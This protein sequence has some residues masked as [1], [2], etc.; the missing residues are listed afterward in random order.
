M[1]PTDYKRVLEEEEKKLELAKKNE[2]SGYLHTVREDPESDATNGEVKK[3]KSPPTSISRPVTPQPSAFGHHQHHN[4]PKVQDL[5]DTIL[6]IKAE[7][8][9]PK[10]LALDKTKGFMTYKQRNEKYRPATSR[11]KD[12]Q[13]FTTRLTKE[14][15]KYQTARCM[16]CGVPFC[17]SDTG[18]PISNVI[19]KWNE[20]IFKDRWYEALQRLLMTN[21]FPEFT[22][23]ICPAPCEGA[24]VLGIN[25]DPVGIKSIE[26]AIIDH[27]F[28]QGWIVP[29]PPQQR[30]G[31]SVVIVGSG[32]AG[33]AA[34]DQLN[35]AGHSV[36][37]YERSDRAGGLLMYGIPNMKLDKKVV[38]RR[39]N[40]MRDEGVNFVTNTTVG[41]D[42]TVSDLKAN[43]DA[44]VFAVGSTI[45]RDLKIPGRSL[46]N[47]MF[48]MQLLKWNTK[49]L[50]EDN[51]D[52]VRELLHD[53]HVIVIGGGDT[54]N[55]CL[56]TSVRHGAKS[57]TNFELLPKPAAARGKDNPWPQWPR[58]FRV[59]YG[60]SEVTAHYGKDPR[61]Y[62]ILSKEFVGDEEVMSKVSRLFEL[63]GRNPK[64]ELGRCLKFQILKNFSQPTLYYCQWDLLV[65]KL[66]L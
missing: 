30:T 64:A 20:L 27:G 63:N 39:L 62:S 51:L 28:E 48:A 54:G 44:V 21:N 13:E 34:A 56:G 43:N 22:G 26:C 41:E 11:T 58:I 10:I 32:P 15:L 6:D 3:I 17:Q 49:S 57:V 59:D 35:R 9:K 31:K 50:L 37:V 8:K 42:I 4:E 25:Q 61:E 40:L 52:E 53:K 16:D 65:Q 5:E 47:I 12:W 7:E 23:R 66:N 24:C 2:I 29:R 14:D 36:T 45:P 19:P 46:N 18:C 38:E 33:L 1:L 55:D 60:D